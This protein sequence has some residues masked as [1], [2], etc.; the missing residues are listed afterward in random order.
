MS[1][2]MPRWLKILFRVLF[3]CSIGLLLTLM[4]LQFQF[5]LVLNLSDAASQVV[6]LILELLTLLSL[7]LGFQLTKQKVLRWVVFGLLVVLVIANYVMTTLSAWE[8]T[9]VSIPTE[10]GEIVVKERTWELATESTLHLK[11]GIFLLALNEEPI[12]TNPAIAPFSSGNAVLTWQENG[13]HVSY[14]DG[15]V[16]EETQKE[17]FIPD[18]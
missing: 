18:R 3:F 14:P 12:L 4:V 2:T 6:F 11:K 8:E 13:L 15:V 10:R 17:I 16:G 5:H 9:M 7:F 1:K